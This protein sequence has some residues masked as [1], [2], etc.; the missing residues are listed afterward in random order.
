MKLLDV[1]NSQQCVIELN[2]MRVQRLL[3]DSGTA[4]KEAR[5][6][7]KQQMQEYDAYR[8]ESPT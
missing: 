6:G 4:S 5:P 8:R 1:P 2:I 7:N 3:E